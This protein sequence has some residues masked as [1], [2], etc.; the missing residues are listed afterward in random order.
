MS[1]AELGRQELQMGR[2]IEVGVLLRRRIVVL[3]AA[4]RV[5]VVELLAA[6]GMMTQLWKRRNNQV[7]ERLAEEQETW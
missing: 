7:L 6:V 3:A 5:M 4:G 1:S 2:R